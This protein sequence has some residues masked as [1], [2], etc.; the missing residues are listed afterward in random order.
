MPVSVTNIKSS[1]ALRGQSV[2]IT[3]DKSEIFILQYLYLGQ[4]VEISS[5]SVLGYIHSIDLYGYSFDVTPIQPDFSLDSLTT[6]GYLDEGEIIYV[7]G[8]ADLLLQE[9]DYALLQEDESAILV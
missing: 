6:P 3:L 5:S 7:D 4:I 8:M 1:Q 2:K 9:N